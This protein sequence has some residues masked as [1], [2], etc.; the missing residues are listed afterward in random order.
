MTSNQQTIIDA[1]NSQTYIQDRM[2]V[3]HTP[4]YDTITLSAGAAVT[5]AATTLFTNVGAVANKTYAQTNMTQSQRLPAPEAFSIFAIRLRWQEDAL[6]ADIYGIMSNLAFEF[7]VG[8]KYYQR[9]P[10]WQYNAGGGVF[11]SAST[12]SATTFLSN[13][14]P[15]RES[16]HKLAIPIVIENQT[17]FYAWLTGGSYTLAT[18]ANGGTGLIFQ[19]LLDGLYARG[20]Q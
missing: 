19:C 18:A 10:I 16:M 5:Q 4:L 7:Y 9:S 14:V 2:D 15:A 17:P 20:V 6:P 3:Q 8:Q 12:A 1:F 13:G 11:A